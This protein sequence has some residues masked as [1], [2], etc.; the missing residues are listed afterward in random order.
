MGE[1]SD[2]MTLPTD[3]KKLR[4]SLV[5]GKVGLRKGLGSYPKVAPDAPMNWPSVLMMP[6]GPAP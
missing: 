1:A 4:A 6:L 5:S 3:M 2:R